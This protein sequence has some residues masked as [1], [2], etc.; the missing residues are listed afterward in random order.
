MD[1]LL[2]EVYRIF[3]RARSAGISPDSIRTCM[4]SREA[5]RTLARR[6][7]GGVRKGGLALDVIATEFNLDGEGLYRQLLDTPRRSELI[8]NFTREF[9]A[10]CGDSDQMG[11]FFE[12]SWAASQ[13][14]TCP[15]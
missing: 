15:F 4:G 9:E 11:S 8:P 5:V 2:N 14:A 6:M 13:V 10:F 3:N 7:P 12:E 1:D